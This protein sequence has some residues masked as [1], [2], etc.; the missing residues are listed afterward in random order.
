MQ[1]SQHVIRHCYSFIFSSNFAV[2]NILNINLG[3][4][5]M[6]YSED[7]FLTIHMD[8]NNICNDSVMHKNIYS[9]SKIESNLL[10]KFRYLRIVCLNSSTYSANVYL[11][12]IYT[13]M[14]LRRKYLVETFRH[15][16][17][18]IQVMVD[19]FWKH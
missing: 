7:Q 19:M 6:M 13:G 10:F 1:H 8:T 9:I 3:L 12:E 11:Q 15:C 16:P 2:H 4:G 17:Q 14:S 5:K 18:Y